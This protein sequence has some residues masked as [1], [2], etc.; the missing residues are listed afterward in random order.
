MVADE[1]VKQ[2]GVAAQVSVGQ[3]DQLSVP[4]R[5]RVLGGSGEELAVAG[6]QCGSHQKWRRSRICGVREDFGRRVGMVADQAVED[7]GVVVGHT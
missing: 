6:Q 4:G 1:H 5:S 7:G 2:V 3:G